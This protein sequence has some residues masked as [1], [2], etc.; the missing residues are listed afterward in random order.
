MSGP[1]P[2]QVSRSRSEG[3]EPDGFCGGE[4]EAAVRREK[5]DDRRSQQEGGASVEE[6]D[7]GSEQDEISVAALNVRKILHIYVYTSTVQN[8]AGPRGS[9]LIYSTFIHV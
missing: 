9:I 2:C 5:R 4:Y 6:S 3:R 7:S 8:T 1:P